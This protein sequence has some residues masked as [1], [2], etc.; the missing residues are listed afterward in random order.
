MKEL[1]KHSNNG[2]SLWAPQTLMTL[3]AK[4]HCNP[5]DEVLHTE[6]CVWSSSILII[7][8]PFTANFTSWELLPTALLLTSSHI[9][10]VCYTGSAQNV[11]TS[12][13][14]ACMYVHEADP[15]LFEKVFNMIWLNRRLATLWKT[16]YH[17]LL[18]L[19][20]LKCLMYVWLKWDTHSFFT[21]FQIT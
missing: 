1:W 14:K 20:S 13:H 19:T 12:T 7:P 18:G 9:H 2:S 6:L 5:T 15:V 4:W 11:H 16:L 10:P 17:G 8:H 21:S 3:M